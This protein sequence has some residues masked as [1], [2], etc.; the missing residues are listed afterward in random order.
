MRR[1][2]NFVKS[3]RDELTNQKPV[4]GRKVLVINN[5]YQALTTISLKKAIN[6]IFTGNAVI[7]VPPDAHNSLW[8]ELDWSDWAKLEPKEGETV[9][10]AACRAFKIPEIIKVVNSNYKPTKRTKFTRRNIFKRDE[11]KCQYCGKQAPNDIDWS[12]LSLD[13]LIPKSRGGKTEW[14][15]IVLC[16]VK[17]NQK[18]N[19][20]LLSECSMKLLKQ[21]IVPP[22][23]AFAETSIRLDSWNHFITDSYFNVELDE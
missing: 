6:K 13:H 10:Q 19:N 23:N 15:N 22:Y 21:P 12:D 7:V 2:S 8:Q 9:I 11:S 18:K 1:N 17:C 4:I 20:R 3:L 14:L 16:C 5:N